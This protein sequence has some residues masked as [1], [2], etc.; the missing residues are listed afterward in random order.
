MHFIVIKYSK[1]SPYQFELKSA[2]LIGQL[3][4]N[5]PVMRETCV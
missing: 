3:V 2:S 1:E 5:L 4:K